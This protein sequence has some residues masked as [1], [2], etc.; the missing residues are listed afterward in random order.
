MML[1]VMIIMNHSRMED[2]KK[3]KCKTCHKQKFVTVKDNMCAQCIS[4]DL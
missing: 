2:Y 1:S 4:L 3:G